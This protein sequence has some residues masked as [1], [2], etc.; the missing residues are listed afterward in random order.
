VAHGTTA[1]FRGRMHDLASLNDL[2]GTP[3]TLELG[4]RYEE[5]GET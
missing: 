1:P 3:E 4:R 5:G 2:I